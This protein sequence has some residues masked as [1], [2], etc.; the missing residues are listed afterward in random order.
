MV[1]GLE[2]EVWVRREGGSRCMYV[3]G[4]KREGGRKCTVR[5]VLGVDNEKEKDGGFL[6]ICRCCVICLCFLSLSLSL[7]PAFSLFDTAQR[8]RPHIL[9]SL[10][11]IFGIRNLPLPPTTCIPAFLIPH[12]HDSQFPSH[13]TPTY[14]KAPTI[15]AF[16]E[17]CSSDRDATSQS[18]H[19]AP[20]LPQSPPSLPCFPHPHRRRWWG[21]APP[22]GE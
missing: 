8:R 22:G 6:M 18:P 10:S 5:G 20:C 4:A 19:W 1:R 11:L 12:N 17:P 3:G 7:E 21:V 16:D 2:E 9:L 14:P 13:T 15:A